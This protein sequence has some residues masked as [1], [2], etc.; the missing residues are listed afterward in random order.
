MIE[1]ASSIFRHR[2]EY[3]CIRHNVKNMFKNT[4]VR[5]VLACMSTTGLL[6]GSSRSDGLNSALQNVSQLQ[7]LDE[8]TGICYKWEG[9]Q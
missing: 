9:A 1:C 4:Y 6:A 7:S 2:A 5:V 8:V 3:T